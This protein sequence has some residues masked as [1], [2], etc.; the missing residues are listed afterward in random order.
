M[1]FSTLFFP[2]LP[3]ASPSGR[4]QNFSCHSGIFVSEGVVRTCTSI[5]EFSWEN[6]CWVPLETVVSGDA[7]LV[8]ADEQWAHGVLGPR[9]EVVAF[10]Q[11]PPGDFRHPGC[12]SGFATFP[13]V[14][15]RG[16]HDFSGHGAAPLSTWHRVSMGSGICDTSHLCDR[17]V[18]F[19]FSLVQSR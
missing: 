11:V 15:S 18:L 9:G 4:L 6:L 1:W 8:L 10:F 12:S 3:P 16:N 2:Y 5:P 14:N 19:P 13:S 7:P 17:E